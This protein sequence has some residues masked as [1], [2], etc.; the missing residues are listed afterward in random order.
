MKKILFFFVALSCFAFSEI[1]TSNQLK[2][3][4]PIP[5]K[6]AEE[7]QRAKQIDSATLE[8][9][10]C[11]PSICLQS[12]CDKRCSEKK[13]R[14]FSIAFKPAYFCPQS[15]LYRHLYDG[16]YLTLF[17]ATYT[18]FKSFNLFLEAGYF[19][20]RVNVRSADEYVSSTITHIPVSLGINYT[21]CVS[22]CLDLFLKVAP[23]WVYTKTWLDITNLKKNV[24][25]NTF[26]GT[27]G[28]GAIYH[29]SKMFFLELF[30]NYLYDKK[31]IHDHLSGESFSRKL[32]GLQVGG[33]V[34][35]RF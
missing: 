18:L 35:V 2:G 5:S 21:L 3:K 32:G 30:V 4:N 27:L 15:H 34:G 31:H 13:C 19:H 28:T 6:K 16:G 12:C 10:S 33:G 9:D 17:E 1:S 7:T 29:I 24:H 11:K 25:K 14:Y 8:K 26:G 20:K 22:S 23:N